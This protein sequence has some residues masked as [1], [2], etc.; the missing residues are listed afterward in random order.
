MLKHLVLPLKRKK[1]GAREKAKSERKRILENAE[2]AA[3]TLLSESRQKAEQLKAATKLEAESALD[4]LKQSYDK[5]ITA[6][7]SKAV[8]ILKS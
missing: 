7:V 2:S 4:T 5:N 1:S 3:D 8:E 6:A